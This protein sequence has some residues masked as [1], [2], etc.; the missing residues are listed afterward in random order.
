M[1]LSEEENQAIAAK[2]E[3]NRISDAAIAAFLAKGGSIVQVPPGQSGIVPGQGNMWGRS[4]KKLAEPVIESKDDEEDV[5][6]E[7]N[8]DVVDFDIEIDDVEILDLE[9]IVIDLDDDTDDS[10]INVK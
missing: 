4:R 10:G 3:A 5:E 2:L 8:M 9:D 1:S 6:I 7:I